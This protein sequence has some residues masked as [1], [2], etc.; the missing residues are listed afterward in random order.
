[1][2]LEMSGT[3]LTGIVKMVESGAAFAAAALKMN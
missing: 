3:R 1:V 2:F